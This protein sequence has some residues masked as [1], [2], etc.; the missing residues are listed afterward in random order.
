MLKDKSSQKAAFENK[1]SEIDNVMVKDP[2]CE[3][4]FAKRDGVHLNIKGRDEYFCSKV[5]ADKFL[6]KKT[7]G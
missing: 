7:K 3:V 2:Y 5:C 1:T 4:Y 6:K